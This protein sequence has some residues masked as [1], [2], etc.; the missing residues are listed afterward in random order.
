M[1]VTFN[2]ALTDESILESAPVTVDVVSCLVISYYSS[3]QNL[4]ME[5]ISSP[6]LL[7]STK[8]QLNVDN[9]QYYLN[10]PAGHYNAIRFRVSNVASGVQDADVIEA[11]IHSFSVLNG[12]CPDT[13]ELNLFGIKL[14]W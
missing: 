11:K 1:G 7:N 3:S 12:V 14:F 13:S 9:W 4:F 10:L 8:F 2:D 6:P 5:I